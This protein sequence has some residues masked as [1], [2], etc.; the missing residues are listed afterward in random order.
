MIEVRDLHKNFGKLEVLKGI[1]TRIQKGEVVVVIGPS[2]SGKSTFLRCLNLLERPTRG[3]VK[4]E[5][6]SLLDPSTDINKI[7][8]DVGMVFQHFNLFPHKTVIENITLAPIKVK[9]IS[10]NDAREKAMELLER[11]G[12]A[13]KAECFPASLSGGQKQR[14][15]IARALA[16]NP[17]VMLFDEPTSALDPEMIK[18][19][20][21]V[22]KDLASDGMTMVVVTHEMRFAR[23]VGDR[24]LFMDEGKILEEGTPKEIFENPQNTRTKE[25]LS[26]IL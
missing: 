24:V 22:M 18:E 19:V 15:A 10:P 14:V 3:E 4:I 8:Q 20:L 13:D 17:K 12:L 16:M 21:D 11:V 2:G 5:G 7:R 26:K 25:F 6:K 23:E 1:N 9:G